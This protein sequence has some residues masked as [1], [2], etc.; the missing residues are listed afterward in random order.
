MDFLAEVN[1]HCNTASKMEAANK[2]VNRKFQQRSIEAFDALLLAIP[3]LLKKHCHPLFIFN[4]TA[5]AWR[6]S[7]AVLHGN[8]ANDDDATT[9]KEQGFAFVLNSCPRD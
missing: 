3:I 1:N 6:H 5:I 7:N 2:T 9:E 4:P 8:N